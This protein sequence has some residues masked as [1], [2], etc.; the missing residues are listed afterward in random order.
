M[1][2]DGLHLTASDTILFQ[3]KTR[4]GVPSLGDELASVPMTSQNINGGD[5][6]TWANIRKGERSVPE[7]ANA[8]CD[9]V[10]G[11]GNRNPAF[12]MT[13]CPA[14]NLVTLQ[15]G[16]VSGTTYHT[17][18]LLITAANDS[19]SVQCRTTTTCSIQVTAVTV[20]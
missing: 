14:Q 1:Q 19:C 3:S 4:S 12:C 16:V 15:G 2:V 6:K 17:S 8:V 7:R 10:T 5:G 11:I 20:L 9:E 13:T 18:R